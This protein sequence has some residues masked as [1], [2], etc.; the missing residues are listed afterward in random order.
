MHDTKQWK[1]YLLLSSLS[2]DHGWLY[3]LSSGW[4]KSLQNNNNLKFLPLQLCGVFF[5]LIKNIC[6]DSGVGYS[7]DA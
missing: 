6:N 5:C 2:D 4:Y 1:M 7:G 3:R